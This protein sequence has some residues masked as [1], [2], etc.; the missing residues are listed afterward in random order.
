[1]KQIISHRITLISTAIALVLSCIWY[2]NSKDIEPLISIVLFAGI[3]IVGI[4]F[5]T[6]TNE[7]EVPKENNATNTADGSIQIQDLT[8]SKVIINK[9]DEVHGDKKE[10]KIGNI[11]NATFN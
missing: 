3:L 9:G 6:Q 4:F 2:Y 7:P 5:H 11:D 8:N 1:M 10:Y